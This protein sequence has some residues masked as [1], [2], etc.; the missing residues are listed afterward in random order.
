MP[1]DIQSAP[2]GTQTVDSCHTESKFPW[3]LILTAGSDF[4]LTNKPTTKELHGFVQTTMEKQ[5]K[6]ISS[7]TSKGKTNKPQKREMGK[8]HEQTFHTKGNSIGS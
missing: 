1:H 8:G 4:L 6:K 2:T 5:N 7:L 3:T